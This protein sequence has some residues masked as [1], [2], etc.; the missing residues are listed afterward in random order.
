MNDD[1]WKETGRVAHVTNN[2]DSPAST[3][4]TVKE[5]DSLVCQA[6]CSFHA[7]SWNGTQPPPHF[8]PSTYQ[9][10]AGWQLHTCRYGEL[11]TCLDMMMMMTT[12]F[13]AQVKI[14]LV[15]V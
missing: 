2:E 3:V 14:W 15:M 12:S 6:S 13:Q 1:D 7:Q 8:Y 4:G 11:A 5:E 9:P 10:W